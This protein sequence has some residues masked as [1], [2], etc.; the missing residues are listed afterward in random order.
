MFMNYFKNKNNI[1]F[2]NPNSSYFCH[3]LN[4]NNKKD[5]LFNPIK[6][7]LSV[8]SK[9]IAQVSIMLFDFLEKNDIPHQ[10]SCI[11]N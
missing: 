4:F 7:Y 1:K 6:M 8:E 11:R 2:F 5:T 10:L 9:D 3:F